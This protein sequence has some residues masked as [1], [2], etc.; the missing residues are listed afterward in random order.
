MRGGGAVHQVA[1]P[2]AV[3][4]GVVEVC[5]TATLCC[6]STRQGTAP[7]HEARLEAIHLTSLPQGSLDDGRPVTALDSPSRGVVQLYLTW[8]IV[9]NKLQNLQ[10][11]II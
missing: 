7:P 2:D 9:L 10:K 3:P 5:P 4:E 8:E 11:K 1:T 6:R